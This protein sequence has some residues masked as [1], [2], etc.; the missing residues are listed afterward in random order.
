MVGSGAYV[1]NTRFDVNV[2]FQVEM[3]ANPTLVKT[4]EQIIIILT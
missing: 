3:R 2:F 1:S 4:Q